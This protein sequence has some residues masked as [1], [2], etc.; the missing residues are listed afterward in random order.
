[1]AIIVYQL[2]LS[3]DGYVDDVEG[4]LVMPAPGDE[5]F[6]HY[7]D[8][9]RGMAGGIYGR[10]IYELMRYWDEDQADW[11]TVHH[12]FA[13]AWRAHPKW[14]ASRTLQSV[15]PG[16]TLIRDNVEA[17]ARKLKAEIDGVITVAGPTLAG[18]LTK[19]DLIDEYRLY[20]RPYV[21]GSGKPFFADTQPK[22]R[23]VSSETIGPETIRA[24]YKRV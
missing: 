2:S 22:L 19:A 24:V 7:T 16:A 10:R 9:E 17:F 8:R 11:G 21:L 6:R 23:F 18:A 20:Y 15:G 14:V 13:A 12:D 1:M 5:E 4:T 3:L